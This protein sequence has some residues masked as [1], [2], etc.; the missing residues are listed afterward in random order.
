MKALR[1]SQ[2]LENPH[3]TIINELSTMRQSRHH[4][5]G[6]GVPGKGEGS[7]GPIQTVTKVPT[8]RQ[9]STTADKL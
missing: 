4:D 5:V 9:S 3:V 7:F 2:T 6:G 8:S 1:N